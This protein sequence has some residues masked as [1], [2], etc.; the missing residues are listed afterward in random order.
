MIIRLCTKDE[1]PLIAAMSEDFAA[2]G[3]CNGINPETV[4]ELA[5]YELYVA[6]EEGKLLGYAYGTAETASR[7][8]FFILPGHKNYYVEIIYVK[9]EYRSRGLGRQLYQK[10]E[11][12]AKELGCETVEVI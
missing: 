12:R 10:L 1:L 2:E 8:R 9:P 3:C 11:D 4:E 7:K 5:A 6:E